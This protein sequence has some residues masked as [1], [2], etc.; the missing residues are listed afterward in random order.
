ME[1]V[2]EVLPRSV[3]G[4]FFY[5]GILAPAE[6]EK[7]NTRVSQREKHLGEGLCA[8]ESQRCL[9]LPTGVGMARKWA[10]DISATPAS[11]GLRFLLPLDYRG[12]Y[13]C[14][15]WSLMRLGWFV[16]FWLVPEAPNVGCLETAMQNSN[17]PL[18]WL[19][20]VLSECSVLLV[21]PSPVCQA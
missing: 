5:R 17:R 2:P 9:Q 4:H 10:Q 11:T 7:R 8:H 19:R 20:W 21:A 13:T 3:Q 16:P 6:H 12:D 14:L 1:S 18:F 15:S